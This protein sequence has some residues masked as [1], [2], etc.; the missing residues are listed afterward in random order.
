MGKVRERLTGKQLAFLNAYV[1]L[2]MQ[3][4][5]QA[6]VKAGY[7]DKHAH[8]VAY[9]LVEH[10]LI[11]LELGKHRQKI[12]SA[13]SVTFQDK[14]DLLWRLAE[15]NEDV[16]PEIVIKSVAEINKMMGHYAPEKSYNVNVNQNLEVK[17]IQDIRSLYKKDV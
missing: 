16:Q 17:E 14:V 10:P 13:I 9:Q 2:G 3:N 15:K 8:K 1:Q 11:K 6:A 5:T 4:A 7:S 12:D